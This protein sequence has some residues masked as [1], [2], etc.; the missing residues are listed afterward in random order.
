MAKV[1]IRE[2]EIEI[3]D[4]CVDLV[5]H[6]NSIGLDTKFCCSGHGKDTFEIMLEDYITDKQIEDFLLANTIDYGNGYVHSW[7]SG[8]LQKWC[9][10]VSGEIKYNWIYSAYDIDEAR[11]DYMRILSKKGE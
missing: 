3:D 5:E 6:F 1:N 8:K 2:Q 7:F 10:V 4:E 9:R 11:R